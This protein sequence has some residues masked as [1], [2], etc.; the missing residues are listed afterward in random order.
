MS[1]A[2]LKNDSKAETPLNSSI[3]AKILRLNSFFMEVSSLTAELY[4]LRNSEQK[5]LTKKEQ[6]TLQHIIHMLDQASLLRPKYLKIV[7][8]WDQIH[9]NN[10]PEEAHPEASVRTPASGASPAARLEALR[11]AIEFKYAK[12]IP[13]DMVQKVRDWEDDVKESCAHPFLDEIEGAIELV[14]QQ[15]KDW[16]HKCHTA[17]FGNPGFLARF[18]AFKLYLQSKSIEQDLARDQLRL[19]SVRSA[20]QRHMQTTEFLAHAVMCHF[21]I[22]DS[23]NQ[24]MMK[25]FDKLIRLECEAEI[26]VGIRRRGQS[27]LAKCKEDQVVIAQKIKYAADAAAYV[28]SRALFQRDLRK[29]FLEERQTQAAAAEERV[30]HSCLVLNAQQLGILLQDSRKRLQML[31]EEYQ[32]QKDSLLKLAAPLFKGLDGS[33]SGFQEEGKRGEASLVSS[34]KTDNWV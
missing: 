8:H 32:F 22:F 6:K 33:Y 26:G 16:D 7:E 34:E 19:A 4:R 31:E 20:T 2:H 14:K 11:K 9:K 10:Q 13:A 5:E 28:R 21:K 3:E 30:L 27:L 12:A 1:D 25:R 23:K 15:K 17:E 29:K 24:P 18:K